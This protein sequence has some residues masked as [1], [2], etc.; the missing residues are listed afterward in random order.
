[1]PHALT[2]L[3][4]LN[5]PQTLRHEAGFDARLAPYRLAADRVMLG[6]CA[7]LALVCLALAPLR[8][9]WPSALVLGGGTLLAMAGLVRAAPGH[10]QTRLALGCAFMVYTGLVIHQTGGSIEGHFTAFGL[11]GVL[12][13]YRDWRVIV[14]ATVFIYLHHLVLGYLQTLGLAVYVFDTPAF[15]T[16]F[17]VHVAYFLPFIAL[18]AYLAISLRREAFDNRLAIGLAREIAEGDFT[19][20]PDELPASAQRDDTLL[21]AVAHMRTRMLE[22]LR[23]LPVAVMIVRQDDGRVADVNP[24]WER[25]FGLRADNVVG[26][27]CQALP[28][29]RTGEDWSAP[30]RSAHRSGRQQIEAPLL[31][32][33]GLP[34][35]AVITCVEHRTP[36]LGL[37][38]LAFEDVT[39]RREAERRMHRLAFEDALTGLANRAALAERLRRLLGPR[40]EAPW[41]LLAIDLDEFKPVND[42]HGHEAG[43]RV[44]Q[45]VGERLRARL[46]EDD[47][48]ARLG[49]DE[50]VVVMPRC[51]EA[52][53]AVAVAEALL[54]AL[55]APV[56]VKPGVYCHVGATIGVA[57]FAPGRSPTSAEGALAAAD[58]ALYDGKRHGRRQVRLRTEHGHAA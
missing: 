10:L 30:V 37:L 48:P 58:A 47:L 17:L 4:P 16:K 38:V 49:G 40:H 20:E 52:G 12:L 14:A 8:G 29:G 33:G 6:M 46:R 55:G 25:L 15:W 45:A 56:N 13:Y 53:D 51:D 43:D 21:N 36:R 3:N 54:A 11:I 19:R 41:A 39:L 44:L 50:F 2:W 23:S 22:L 42:Q 24:D 31:R 18:M 27:P 9:T 26:K 35:A 1:M 28:L 5:L 57:W 7:F 34:L 32:A